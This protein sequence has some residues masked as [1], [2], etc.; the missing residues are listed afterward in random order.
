MFKPLL[1]ITLPEDDGE[2]RHFAPIILALEAMCAVNE[3]HIKRSLKRARLGKGIPV[4]PLYA[5]GVRYK[6][7]DA[8]REDWR[9]CY[10]ILKR[11]FGDCDNLVAYRV[12]ELRAAGIQAD[13]V[14]KWQHVP[15]DIAVKQLGY[16]G[17]LIP[18]DGFWM[19]HC[20]VRFPDGRI[21]DPSKLLGMGG[22]YTNR[23]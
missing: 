16:P 10:V 1:H 13:P 4:P 22:H 6:E 14:V 8:G 20:A 15:K 2:D 3:W 23:M 17:K 18:D 19:V 11:G 12:G 5:T 7:D 9:D 21:E